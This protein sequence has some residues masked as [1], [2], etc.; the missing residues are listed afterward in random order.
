MYPQL[1]QLELQYGRNPKFGLLCQTEV[2]IFYGEKVKNMSF[3]VFSISSGGSIFNMNAKKS[4]CFHCMLRERYECISAGLV[5]QGWFQN[6]GYR[7]LRPAQVSLSGSTALPITPRCTR[8]AVPVVGRHL[9][10][11][12]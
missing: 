10:G 3:F 4:I 5:S 12:S 9:A 8:L 11:A 2:T 7:V 1:F 6:R